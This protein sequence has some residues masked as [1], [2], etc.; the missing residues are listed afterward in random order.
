M[1][2]PLL[3]LFDPDPR[4]AEREVTLLRRRLILYF[5]HNRSSCSEDRAHD[6][7]QRLL[8]KLPELKGGPEKSLT[9]I[10]LVRFSF[11]IAGK[12]AMEDWRGRERESRTEE[13]SPNRVDRDTRVSSRR[14]GSEERILAKERWR[15]VQTCLQTLNAA[16]RDLLLSWYREE[17]KAHN[18]LAS[19]LGINANTLRIRIHRILERVRECVRKKSA[20]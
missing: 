8:A 9:A 7:F 16:D 13:L 5:Q 6:V 1:A 11:G 3:S 4:K 14:P 15:F 17:T 20:K 12:V 2:D 19:S 10:D 18:V